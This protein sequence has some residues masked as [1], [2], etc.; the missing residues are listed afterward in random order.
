M[1]NLEQLNLDFNLLTGTVP[2]ALGG[3]SALKVVYLNGNEGLSGSLPHE[4]GVPSRSW[5]AYEVDDSGFNTKPCSEA[6]GE[7]VGK[8]DFCYGA[9]SFF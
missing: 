4:W 1:V 2:A 5:D 9:S 6:D 8:L 7:T 3:L